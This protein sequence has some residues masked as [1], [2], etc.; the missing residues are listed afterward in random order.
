[1]RAKRAK[2]PTELNVARVAVRTLLPALG[3]LRTR[4]QTT[5]RVRPRSRETGFDLCAL[6]RLGLG[7]ERRS[8]VALAARLGRALLAV[9]VGSGTNRQECLNARGIRGHPQLPAPSGA[10]DR[11]REILQIRT[12]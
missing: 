12:F 4:S 7:C 10:A 6:G 3:R 5:A 9:G 2:S 11:M 8:S 1:M